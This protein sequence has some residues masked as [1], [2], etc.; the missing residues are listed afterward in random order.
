[1]R[2]GILTIIGILL[3]NCLTLAQVLTDFESGTGGWARNSHRGEGVVTAAVVADP[4]ARAEGNVLEISYDGAAA[5]TT[6]SGQI[7]A[8]S[9]DFKNADIITF[10]VYVPT[11]FPDAAEIKPI[12][13]DGWCWCDASNQTYKGIDIPKDKW[14]PVNFHIRAIA[15]SNSGSFSPYA[16]GNYLAKMQLAIYTAGGATEEERNWAGK[17]YV[18]NITAIGS[19]PYVDTDF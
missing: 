10:W 3:L 4:T 18:D 9:Y 1:M 19:S 15:I 5:G 13:Q 12:G 17:I 7:Q 14:Y 11:G 2:K 16:S 8:D 6:G